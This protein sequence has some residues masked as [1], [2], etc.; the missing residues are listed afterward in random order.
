MISDLKTNDDYSSLL[1]ESREK[2]IF[3]FKHSSACPVSAMAWR[4]FSK[5]AHSEDNAKYWKVLV[6][7]DR[8]LSMQVAS[9]TGIRHQSPQVILF[10][11]GEPVWNESHWSISENSLNKA[12]ANL[13]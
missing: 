1:E 9:E 10:H 7:E 2:P 13:N 8:P 11:N 6:I 4:A 12:L 5:F 3:L